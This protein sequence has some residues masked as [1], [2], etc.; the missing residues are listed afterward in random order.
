MRYI[1]LTTLESDDTLRG[2]FA[3]VMGYQPEVITRHWRTWTNSKYRFV[4][5]GP[6]YPT[7]V[8]PCVEVLPGMSLLDSG[9][10]RIVGIV[11]GPNVLCEDD[12]LVTLSDSVTVRS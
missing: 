1:G 12:T 9:I 4:T 7:K 6:V 10:W 8:I 2:E 5:L 3:R 11:D